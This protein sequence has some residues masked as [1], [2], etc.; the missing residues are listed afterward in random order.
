[1]SQGSNIEIVEDKKV[2]NVTTANIE[3]YI[4]VNQTMRVNNQVKELNEK[5]ER[6]LE[7]LRETVNNKFQKDGWIYHF[8]EYGVCREEGSR[9]DKYC[10][11][12]TIKAFKEDTKFRCVKVRYSYPIL[13]HICYL[14]GKKQYRPTYTFIITSLYEDKALLEELNSYRKGVYKVVCEY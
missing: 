5:I 9:I 11:P 1:M 14:F 13:L 6:E 4:R 12:E 3:E 10:L 7:D 2:E 8:V